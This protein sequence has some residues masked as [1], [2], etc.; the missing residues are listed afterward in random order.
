MRKVKYLEI[1]SLVLLSRWSDAKFEDPFVVGELES[2]HTDCRGT[3]YKV[4]EHARQFK[5]CFQITPEERGMIEHWSRYSGGARGSIRGAVK[6]YSALFN[7]A[8]AQAPNP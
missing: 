6:R 7:D 4:K 5:N 2:I 3:C 1:G 8:N